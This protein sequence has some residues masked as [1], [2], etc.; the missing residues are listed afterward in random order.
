MSISTDGFG[1]ILS[2]LISGGGGGGGGALTLDPNFQTADFTAEVGKLYLVETGGG[3]VN[4]TFPYT[5]SDGDQF[6][7]V[8]SGPN[9]INLFGFYYD[10][11]S[12]PSTLGNQIVIFQRVTIFDQEFWFVVSSSAGDALKASVSS[13]FTSLIA[14]NSANVSYD[15]LAEDGAGTKVKVPS[16]LIVRSFSGVSSGATEGESGPAYTWSS[17]D[18]NSNVAGNGGAGGGLYLAPG[19]GGASLSNGRGGFGGLLSLV[20]GNGGQGSDAGGDG[21]DAS[22]TA[23]GGGSSNNVGGDGGS[24]SFQAGGGGSANNHGGDGGILSFTGGNGG[25]GVDDSGGDGGSVQIASGNGGVGAIDGGDAGTVTITSGNGQSGSTGVGGI[26][27]DITITPGQ[28]GFGATG[29]GQGGTLSLY[30]GNGGNGDTNDGG[31]GGSVTFNAGGGG[32][33][34]SADA[35]SAGNITA[36][37]GQGGHGAQ[38]NTAGGY[39]NIYGGSG[40]SQIYGGSAGGAVVIQGGENT[41]PSVNP[42]S[43]PLPGGVNITGGLGAPGAGLNG[44]PGGVAAVTGGLGGNSDTNDGGTGGIAIFVAGDGGDGSGSGGVGGTTYIA[45]GS[46]GDGAV[47]A[48]GGDVVI[49]AADGGGGTPSGDPGRILIGTNDPLLAMFNQRTGSIEMGNTTYYPPITQIGSV[50]QPKAILTPGANIS[51]DLAQVTNAEVT[52][53]QNSTLDFAN[54]ADGISGVILVKQDANGGWTLGNGTGMLTPGGTAL[55][56]GTGV[57][58]ASAIDYYCDG[59]NVYATLRGASFS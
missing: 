47:G 14:L 8:P 12:S 9:P 7:L 15:L 23:G 42:I 6:G 54:L 37:A 13:Q 52:L 25:N 19:V 57:N 36:S 16:N 24:V 58:A 2:D 30:G 46:G 1:T 49:E 55:S 10:G 39:V 31:A 41:D 53:D 20:S 27:G 50:R 32:A 35:G 22:I 33:S 5:S 28:G 3:A 43:S 4:V 11:S 48:N 18:G 44:A 29:G 38:G 51:V 40:T 45:A 21:G 17:A 34:N 26:G 59:T 56:I